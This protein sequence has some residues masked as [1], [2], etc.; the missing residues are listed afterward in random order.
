VP[1]LRPMLMAMAANG[2]TRR[3][4]TRSAPKRAAGAKRSSPK[5]ETRERA[6]PKRPPAGDKPLTGA[7]GGVL[8]GSVNS[9]MGS[10]GLNVPLRAIARLTGA[11][12]RAAVVLERVDRATRH[13]DKMD[14]GFVDRLNDS[15]QVLADMR[16]DT[17]AMRA[18]V[19]ELERE[20]RGLQTSLTERLDRVPLMRPSKRERKAN[21]TA[22]NGE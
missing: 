7:L 8:R 6:Q 3:A 15:F 20:V 16:K 4:S 10:V 13:L 5:R 18:R 9:V 1:S 12:E 17:R 21:V 19:D 2:T 11:V 22:E 14:A